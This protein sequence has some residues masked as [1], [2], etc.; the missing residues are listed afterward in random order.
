M[1]QILVPYMQGFCV[2]RTNAC[3]GFF[4]LTE[5]FFTKIPLVVSLY[6][7]IE[8]QSSENYKVIKKK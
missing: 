2:D 8:K 4:M 3:R 7:L 6:R 1:V 5:D